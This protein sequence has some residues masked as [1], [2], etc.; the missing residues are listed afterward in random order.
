M[1]LAGAQDAL[2]LAAEESYQSVTSLTVREDVGQ[3]ALNQSDSNQERAR[4]LCYSLH[5]L[6]AVNVSAT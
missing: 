5:Y 3:P 6:Q 4:G 2:C 1:M